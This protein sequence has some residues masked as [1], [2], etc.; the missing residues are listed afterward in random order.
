M[1]F[2]P[3]MAK[4]QTDLLLDHFKRFPTITSV[5]ASAMFK[6]RSLSRRIND[7]EEL[8]YRVTRETKFDTMGQKYVRYH[9]W[10]KARSAA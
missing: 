10:G 6:I 4:R 7:L 3:V 2:T 8:G 1:S 5:E 9:F